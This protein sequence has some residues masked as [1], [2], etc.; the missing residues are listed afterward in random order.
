MAWSGKDGP[1]A[2]MAGASYWRKMEVVEALNDDDW[3]VR[4]AA[5]TELE[6]IGMV[7]TLA[8]PLLVQMWQDASRHTSERRAAGDALRTIFDLLGEKLPKRCRVCL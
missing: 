3:Q 5:A 6:T 2:D 1:W 7:A 8:I 4:T